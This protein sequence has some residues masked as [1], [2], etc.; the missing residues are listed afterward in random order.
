M[1]RTRTTRTKGKEKAVT[2]PFEPKVDRIE[3]NKLTMADLMATYPSMETPNIQAIISLKQEFL[4]LRS[5]ITENIPSRGQYFNSQKL[6]KRIVDVYDRHIIFARAGSGKSCT[7]VNI[8]ESYINHMVENVNINRAIYVVKGKLLRAEMYK[9]IA[10]SCTSK[11][12]YD[13]PYI[14]DPNAT[15]STQRHRLIHMLEGK[16]DIVTLQKFASDIARLYGVR[17]REKVG[18][19]NMIDNAEDLTSPEGEFDLLAGD[20]KVISHYSNILIFIDEFHEVRVSMRKIEELINKAPPGGTNASNSRISLAGLTSKQIE[21]YFMHRMA[22]LVKGTKLIAATATTPYDDPNE[23]TSIYNIMLPMNKQI[24]SSLDFRTITLEQFEYY[25]RGLL[26]HF[27]VPDIGVDEV[28]PDGSI[29]MEEIAVVDGN[30]PLKIKPM[31]RL[32]PVPMS[33]F[34]TKIYM[35][36][37]GENREADVH[38]SE[39]Q[40]STFVYP[41]G[42]FGKRGFDK[43]IGKE[44]IK[45]ELRDVLSI[46]KKGGLEKYSAIYYDIIKRCKEVN[47]IHYVYMEEIRGSGG[48]VFM[49]ALLANGFEE[50]SKEYERNRPYCPP[51]GEK[52]SVLGPKPK[53]KQFAIIR[54]ELTETQ[55]EAIREV[56]TSPENINGEYISVIIITPVGKLGLNINHSVDISLVSGTWN[57]QDQRQAIARAI[58]VNGYIDVLKRLRA[59]MGPDARISVPIYHYIAVPQKQSP[60]VSIGY[61]MYRQAIEKDYYVMRIDRMQTQVA[62]NCQIDYDRNLVRGKDGSDKCHYGACKYECFGPKVLDYD[63]GEPLPGYKVDNSTYYI[64]YLDSVLESITENIKSYFRRNNVRGRASVNDIMHYFSHE[65]VVKLSPK[66]LYLA[67]NRLVGTVSILDTYGYSA[68]IREDNGIFY[69][70]RDFM[71][72]E[73]S[74]L[75]SFYSQNLLITTSETLA[76]LTA[77]INMSEVANVTTVLEAVEEFDLETELWKLSPEAHIKLWEESYIELLINPNIEPNIKKKLEQ[78]VHRHKYL[79]VRMNIPYDTL[80]NVIKKIENVGKGA[81]RKPKEGKKPEPDKIENEDEYIEEELSP[82]I[83]DQVV[84]HWLSSVISYSKQEFNAIPNWVNIAAPMRILNLG[85]KKP[86]WRN[87][88]D[89]ENKVYNEYAQLYTK[90]VVIAPFRKRGMYGVSIDPL[91]VNKNIISGYWV[92]DRRDDMMQFSIKNARKQNRGRRCVS[93]KNTTDIIWYLY[94]EIEIPPGSP[95]TLND[96]LPIDINKIAN[97]KLDDVTRKVASSIGEP[98][99][100]VEK[101]DPVKIR[102]YLAILLL[103]KNVNTRCEIIIGRLKVLGLMIDL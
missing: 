69:L 94:R 22:H 39:I 67:L 87:M 9:Q 88:D 41:D 34:Q 1:R 7:L 62:V 64:Y 5:K 25:A 74:S 79:Y 53:A 24:P 48:I 77:R 82:N 83:K 36:E 101:W 90:E 102:S 50:F 23:T 14:N 95:A 103:T 61:Q 13:T 6:T 17:T 18:R 8:T 35:E 73:P 75:M 97:L 100:E 4:E 71:E 96:P 11:G 42:S 58:R 3:S 85:D 12:T 30:K 56:I 89:V 60:K 27:R 65:S 80:K 55:F 52:R 20:A 47:G 93:Y 63:T 38:W 54:S 76:A 49:N 81:G 46:D 72:T 51:S 2:I 40:S 26:T 68:Y 32:Y 31:M 86:A 99:E 28:Y 84:I 44:G 21:Y 70:D 98:F 29:P 59:T 78:I 10:C 66:I 16:Y 92:S 57:L 33:Q 19:G 43:Y 91:G 15:L 37:T 45:R